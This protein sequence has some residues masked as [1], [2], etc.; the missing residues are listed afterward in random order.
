MCAMN[1]L[2]SV[3]LTSQ[4]NSVLFSFC[5]SVYAHMYTH[6]KI[7]IFNKYVVVNTYLLKEQ[8][9][10]RHRVKRSGSVSKG[11]LL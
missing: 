11:C 9:Q 7:N 10:S 4:S 6:T 1:L 2:M 5:E 3:G 8:K